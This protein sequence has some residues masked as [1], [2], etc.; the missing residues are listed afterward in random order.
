[1]ATSFTFNGK[2]IKLPG[3]YSQIQAAVNNQPLDLSSGNVIIIDK[4][5]TKP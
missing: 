1:M 4:D 5:A 2:V 3:A